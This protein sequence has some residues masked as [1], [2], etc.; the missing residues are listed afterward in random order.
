[1]NT[2]NNGQLPEA[3]DKA[4][5]LVENTGGQEKAGRKRWLFVVIGLV[6]VLLAAI[7]IGV[8][9]FRDSGRRLQEQLDLGAKYLEEMDYEQA[10]VAFHAV[11]EIEPRNADA[12]LGIVEVYIRMNDFESALEYAK[13]GYEVTEDER[14]KEKIDMIESGDIFA[15]NGWQMKMSGYDGDGNLMFWHEYTYNLQGQMASVAKYNDQGVQEQYL[16]LA[17]D[18]EGRKLIKYGY[19]VTTGFLNKATIEYSG[20]NYRETWYEGTSDIA[21]YYRECEVDSEGK[22]LMYTYCNMDGSVRSTTVYEY[23]EDG[24][25]VRSEGYNADNQLTGYMIY[26]YNSVGNSLQDQH[27]DEEGNLISYNEYVYDDDGN[28]IGT[29]SYDGNGVLQSERVY[30]NQSE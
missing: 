1:M 24:K 18:E 13:E 19:G 7:I 3:E 22:P 17:Y 27:Y 20:N 8:T 29:R 12:Y 16:E 25:R 4:A 9:I 11:L 21:S 14:L 23:D 15:S 6:L 5:K 10:L 2:E 30:N 26:T 28:R